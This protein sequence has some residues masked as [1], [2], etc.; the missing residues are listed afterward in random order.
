MNMQTRIERLEQRAEAAQTAAAMKEWELIL[1]GLTDDELISLQAVY[2]KAVATGKPVT[3]YITP[4][5]EAALE[6]VKR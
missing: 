3:D 4:E 6:R 5:L 1:A 2:S